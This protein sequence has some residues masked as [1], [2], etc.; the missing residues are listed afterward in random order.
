[1]LTKK[2]K[3][4]K[5]AKRIRHAA[6]VRARETTPVFVLGE[7][8]SGTNMLMECFDRSPDTDIFNETDD[9]A[10]DGYML[11]D[12][13]TVAGL[14]DRSK[15]TH[16][17]FK[18]IADSARASELLSAFPS[19]RIVWIFR[20]YEDVVNSAMRK[21]K[22]HNRYL[23]DV[24]DNPDRAKWRATNVSDESKAIVREHYERGL[25]E[26]SARALIW[27][28]RNRPFFEQSLM[29][30]SEVYLINYEDLVTDPKSH[31]TGVLHFVNLT[32]RSGLVE[33]VSPK[34]IGRNDPPK[35]DRQV[36]SLCQGLFDELSAVWSQR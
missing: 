8:R 33:H 6:V 13:E 16:A 25:S 29:D 14:I 12:L 30:R 22:E 1:M 35:I 24:L 28:L 15:A 10:F 36:H 26:E 11:R 23:E 20:R 21:W 7:M 27:Y 31:L 34:S 5:F 9:E 4:R 3:L 18:A 19:A 2:E 32:F 17:V